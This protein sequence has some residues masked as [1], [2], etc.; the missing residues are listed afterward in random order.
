MSQNDIELVSL[1]IAENTNANICFALTANLPRFVVDRWVDAD[2]LR[3]NGTVWC[4][5]YRIRLHM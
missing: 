1:L 5:H 2:L 4:K 3:Y